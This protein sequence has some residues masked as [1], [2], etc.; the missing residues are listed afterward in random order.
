MEA[1]KLPDAVDDHNEDVLRFVVGIVEAG[2]DDDRNDVADD[3]YG[4]QRLDA[5]GSILPGAARG[6]AG[7]IRRIVF[8]LV[9]CAA[10]K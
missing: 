4:E 3:E 5:G 10:M 7:H 6:A 2:A 1:E 8:R 9:K